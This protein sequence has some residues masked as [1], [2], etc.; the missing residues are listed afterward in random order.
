MFLLLF[1]A[2]VFILLE[3]VVTSLPL[4]LIAVLLMLILYSVKYNNL[5]FVLAFLGG[6]VLDLNAV[7]SLGGASLFLT[8]W[9]FFVLLYQRKY[10]IDTIPFVFVSSFFGTFLYLW[11]FGYEDIFIQSITGS[12]LGGALF[13]LFRG[14]AISRQDNLEFNGL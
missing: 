3:N 6:L 4:F 12:F 1:I 8:C 7:R 14:M 2:L 9:L 5:V 10:E 11:F 13:I